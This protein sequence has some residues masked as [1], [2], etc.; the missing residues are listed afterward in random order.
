MGKGFVR[1]TGGDPRVAC[2][3]L[4][5]CGVIT[6]MF[7]C[8][9]GSVA[10]AKTNDMTDA[11]ISDA[12][13]KEF[14]FDAAVPSNE[15]DVGTTKGIVTLTGSV[16]NLLAK[17]RATTIALTVKGVRSVVNRIDVK[18]FWGR[19][20]R[21]IEQ[22]AVQAL[23]KNPATESWEIRVDVE[24]KEA[25]L[26]GTVD[27]W[28]EKQF[29]GKL[30]MGVKGV[31]GIDN[32]ISVLYDSERKDSEILAD[33]QG[34]LRWD[35][36]VDHALID[37]KVDDG[38]VWLSGTVGSA[39]EKRQAFYD[40]WVAGVKV[41]N[42]GGLEVKKWARDESMRKDKYAIKPD[43]KVEDAIEWALIYDPRVLSTAVEADASKGTVTLRGEVES[44]SAKRA[45]AQDARNTVGVIRIVNLL[46]VR[47][48][49]V[50]DTLIE[51]DIEAAL[52]RDPYVERYEI[53]VNVVDQT[54][55]LSGSVDSYFEK[56]QAEQLAASTYGVKEV[57]NNLEVE[58]GY[59][60]V[61][62]PFVD[63]FYPYGYAWYDY[64]PRYTFKTDAEVRD[65]IQDELWWSPYVDQNEV[66]VSV[67]D[68]RARLTGTVDTWAERHAATENAYEGGAVWVDNDLIVG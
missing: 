64:E 18:P 47:P 32:R 2:G 12:V 11:Q 55:Y 48:T 61:Y 7:L 21:E 51:E 33:V 19:S 39:A 34:A 57:R 41:V 29:A 10:V 44:L 38:K 17:E 6:L 3:R 67:E 14:V 26:T 37:V 66:T 45:A 9:I 60:L 36:R 56:G 35:T 24:G 62:D 25:E 4:L 30:V 22:D 53:F 27:S 20:D 54:A 52:K 8:A 49:T 42:I 68:G 28:Q 16:N 63:D 13:V 50:S 59:P 46:K 5:L 15:I 31:K 1:E 65:Q 40:A 43:E 58:N 23:A